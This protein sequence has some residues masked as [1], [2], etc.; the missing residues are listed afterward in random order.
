MR[1]F[2]IIIFSLLF[3]YTI[4]PII[5]QRGVRGNVRNPQNRG[6][7]LALARL[8]TQKGNGLFYP[9][10]NKNG[11]VTRHQYKGG[12][13]YSRDARTFTPVYKHANNLQVVP[14]RRRGGGRQPINLG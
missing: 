11:R 5:A 1:L 8:Y 12:I 9:I 3:S 13:F 2:E 14:P 6:G 7:P 4:L 10:L